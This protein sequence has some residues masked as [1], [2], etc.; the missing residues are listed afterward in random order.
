MSEI[1]GESPIGVDESPSNRHPAVMVEPHPVVRW[2][3]GMDEV[4]LRSWIADAL[5]VYNAAWNSGDQAT[6]A[7]FLSTGL[8]YKS[9]RMLDDSSSEG[10][11][12]FLSA[13]WPGRELYP[14]VRSEILE[15]AAPGFALCKS[16]YSDDIDNE[17]GVLQV[18]T[19]EDGVLT[20]LSIFEDDEEAAARAEFADVA[21]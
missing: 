15:V 8:S 11:D 6:A 3:P 9:S 1:C 14:R 7:R 5:D 2:R 10:R 16:L 4:A 17:I 13:Q 21:G 19:I 18:M 20:H 12:S